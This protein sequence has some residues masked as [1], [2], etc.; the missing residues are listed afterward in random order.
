MNP[1]PAV[2]VPG[3]ILVIDDNPIIQRT[4][5]FALRDKGYKVFMSGEIAD[6]LNIVRKEQPDLILL[7]INFPPDAASRDGFWALDWM[8]R[9]DEAKDIPIVV[10]SG[11]APEKSSARAIAAGAAAYFH[12]PINKDELAAAIAGLLACKLAS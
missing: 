12:K 2:T 10:I 8:Q 5:Y 4:I 11:D 9:M 6:A 1:A 7:D 3:K